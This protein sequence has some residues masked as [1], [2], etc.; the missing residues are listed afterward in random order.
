[1]L[2]AIVL[3][4]VERDKI[5]SVA[6]TVADLEGVSEVYSVAGRYDLAAIVRVKTNDDLAKVVTE[7]IR[8]VPGIASS[9]TLI[10]FRVYSRHDLERMFSI[11]M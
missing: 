2:S 11:G 8:K 7:H 4:T 6:D 10:A 9:E 3:L 1:M 5:N